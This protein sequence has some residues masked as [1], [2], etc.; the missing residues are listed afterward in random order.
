MERAGVVEKGC[1][2]ARLRER[3]R[4]RKRVR[5]YRCSTYMYYN[6]LPGLDG[7]GGLDHD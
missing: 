7:L 4:E 5:V 3:E 2:G 1:A 6:P